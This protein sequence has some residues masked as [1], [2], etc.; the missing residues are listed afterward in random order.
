MEAFISGFADGYTVMM[1]FHG[2]RR[3]SGGVWQS[4]REARKV[5]LGIA[6]KDW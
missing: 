3:Y 4:L 6:D 1:A 2:E 5:R